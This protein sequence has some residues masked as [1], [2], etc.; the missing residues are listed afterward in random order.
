M[1]SAWLPPQTN[2]QLIDIVEKRRNY[3][4]ITSFDP[5]VTRTMRR[6]DRARFLPPGCKAPYDDE[7]AAIGHGQTCS[8]PSMVAAMAT[9]LK[10]NLGMKVLEIGAGCGY[11]AAVTAALIEP[12]GELI[13][14]EF[15]PELT[16]F[17]RA[18]LAA[19]PF[20]AAVELLTGDGSVGLPDRAPFDRIYMTAGA[21]KRF[22]PRILLDQLKPGGLLLYPES[23][24]SLYLYEKQGAKEKMTEFKS[25]GFVALRGENCGFD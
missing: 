17:A 8:Q 20:S 21:G 24:G 14:I 25:V 6:F 5:R 11:S 12:N 15:V 2:D 7:P 10:L 19:F 4:G 9:L 1:T 3:L 18:N 23:F 22:N 16:G 13:S